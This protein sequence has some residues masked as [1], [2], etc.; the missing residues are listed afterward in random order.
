[1][2]GKKQ[3][4]TADTAGVLKKKALDCSTEAAAISRDTALS[5]HD[6]VLSYG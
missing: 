3:K 6:P 2:A 1:M 5:E 4:D